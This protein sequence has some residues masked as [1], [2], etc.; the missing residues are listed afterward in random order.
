MLAV[1]SIET[2]NSVFNIT[3]ENN[4]FSIITPGHWSTEN[5]EETINKL[6]KLLDPRSE[7]GL[8][9]HINEVNK[10]GN[11]I[12]LDGEEYTYYNLIDRSKYNYIEMLKENRYDDIEDMVYR[13]EF[14]KNEYLDVL[15]PKCKTTSTIGY[16]LPHGLFKIR[17]IDFMLQSLLPND[18]E[19]KIS[20]D[21]IRLR[22]NLSTNRAIKFRKYSFFYTISGFTESRS[23]LLND[24]NGF[25]QIIPGH[26]KA[27]NQLTL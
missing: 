21:D 15:H 26:I 11:I 18:V 17:D 4:S 2:S 23:N 12:V 3:G 1:T 14:T 27:T 19:V 5:D 8:D 16:T 22:S 7:N 24:I 9:L 13:L 25:Y 6:N 10:R 20:I